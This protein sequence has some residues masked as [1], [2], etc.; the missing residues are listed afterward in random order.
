M[1]LSGR[2][3]PTPLP[4][5][6]G[7]APGKGCPSW[8]SLWK[9]TLFCL[10]CLPAAGEAAHRPERGPPA[11]S[12]HPDA[13]FPEVVEA[14]GLPPG[15]CPSSVLQQALRVPSPPQA[16]R[17]QPADVLVPLSLSGTWSRLFS[18]LSL[19]LVTRMTLQFIIQTE[20]HE[21]RY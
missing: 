10:T 7:P 13:V 20:T 19:F 1:S 4:R 6:A 2:S 3:L 11:S 16:G 18:Q 14:P 9:G 15:H 5:P 17:V 12:F 8:P 21:A